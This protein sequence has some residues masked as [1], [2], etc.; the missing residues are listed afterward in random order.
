MRQKQGELEQQIGIVEKRVAR[1]EGLAKIGAVP[2]VNLDEAILELKGL[3]ERRAELDKVRAESEKLI[4]PVSGVVASANAVAGQIADI[5]SIVFQIVDPSRL[6]IEALT[7]SVIP[8]AQPASARTSEGKTLVL[9]FQ[10]AGLTDRSQAIP[11][12][13]AIQGA[14]KGLRVGQLVT[15][16]ATTGEEVRGL[17]IPRTSVLRSSNGQTVV[18]E[19]TGAERFEPRIVRV[20]PLDA[21]RAIVLDGLPAGARVVAQ[22][23][24]LLNQIR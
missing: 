23:A 16:L 15:V 10:G 2:K 9:S 3:R 14:P 1:Y 22:G 20:E 13:F 18:F 4:A 8:D 11:V 7:F 19:H 12:Q 6:W 17:A 21:D 5:N 24:E